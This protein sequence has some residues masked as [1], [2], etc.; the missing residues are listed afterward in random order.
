MQID[1][2]AMEITEIAMKHYGVTRKINS[3]AMYT[4]EIAMKSM[5]WQWKSMK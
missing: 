1:A 3:I 4:H 5:N 2:K